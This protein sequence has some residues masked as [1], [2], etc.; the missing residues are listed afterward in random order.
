MKQ[1]IGNIALT[2]VEN[3]LILNL[4]KIDCLKND[5]YYYCNTVAS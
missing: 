4:L 5:S 3:R 1:N 2:F